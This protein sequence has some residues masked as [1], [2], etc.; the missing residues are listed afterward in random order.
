MMHPIEELLGKTTPFLKKVFAYLKKDKINV[1][2][3]ELDHICYRVETLKKYEELKQKFLNHGSLL[4]ETQIGGR[5]ISSFKLHVP[6]TFDNR[7]IY[8]IELPAPKK[9]RFYPEGYEHVEFVV[10]KEFNK[11]MELYPKV[12]FDTRA[13]SKEINPDISINYDGC[14][15]KF[16]H[17]TLEYV[18][19]YLE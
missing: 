5:F 15:V 13:M 1:S 2:S 10:D 16:H 6:I 11:F 19:T 9:G 14:S 18:I 4:S 8:C 7:K 12:N 17:N 3:Y